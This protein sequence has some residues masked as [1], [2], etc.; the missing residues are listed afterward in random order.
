[1]NGLLLLITLISTTV[2]I[3]MSVVAWRASR[4][5]RR[6][7]DARVSA[8]AADIHAAPLDSVDLVLRPE[9]AVF[10]S[11]DRSAPRPAVA[12]DM[13]ATSRRPSSQSRWGIALIAGV[14]A[15]A[16]VAAVAVIFSGE[17]R[18]AAVSAAGPGTRTA[19]SPGGAVRGAPQLTLP[20]DLIALG[21]ERDG[22]RLIVR[23][24]VQNPPGGVELD[25]LVAVVF[26]F[27][28]DG[29]FRTT[30]QSA[31]P[32]QALPP[33]ARSSFVVSLPDAADVVRYRVSF[34][35]DDHVVPHADR[36]GRS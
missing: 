34:R 23:G 16:A 26:G 8:L 35:T 32:S 9:P 7:S 21:Q 5:E 18:G 25:R 28:K 24:V 13:F 6:R 10:H 36:R 22:D 11:A 3:V 19:S 33:G 4:E 20:L 2:A 27:G 12:S 14:L 31:L 29:E 1:M 15:I 30:G 17:S